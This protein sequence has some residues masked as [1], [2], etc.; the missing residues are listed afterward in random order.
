MAAK[1]LARQSM[2]S[3][4]TLREIRPFGVVL[5]R[6]ATG[7]CVDEMRRLET[8]LIAEVVAGRLRSQKR[9]KG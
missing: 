7:V 1:K 3:T 2:F 6:E 5:F 4:T 9:S 8:D